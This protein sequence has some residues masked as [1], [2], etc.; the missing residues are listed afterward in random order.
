[1]YLHMDL[2]AKL[3]NWIKD[4]ENTLSQIDLCFEGELQIHVMQYLSSLH[5]YLRVFRKGNSDSEVRDASKLKE[6]INQ[7]R[8]HEVQK[9]MKTQIILIDKAV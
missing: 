9:K 8:T 5:E 6:A 7:I 4:M 2:D 3:S 1:M